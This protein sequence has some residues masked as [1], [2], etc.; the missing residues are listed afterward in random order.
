MLDERSIACGHWTV[1]NLRRGRQTKH[2]PSLS[3]FFFVLF[4]FDLLSTIFFYLHYLFAG[5]EFKGTSIGSLTIRKQN[6][7]IEKP[8][9]SSAVVWIK[10]NEKKTISL[11]GRLFNSVPRSASLSFFFPLSLHPLFLRFRINSRLRREMLYTVLRERSCL[12]RKRKPTT[13]THVQS[14]T[15]ASFKKK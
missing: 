3:S 9:S 5:Q 10:R 7:K 1:I 8:R 11:S 6:K 15:A 14:E 2:W 12:G 4:S 13:V